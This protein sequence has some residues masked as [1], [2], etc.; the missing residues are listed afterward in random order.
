MNF[1]NM[2][3]NAGKMNEMNQQ[4]FTSMIKVGEI[5]TESHSKLVGKQTA[6]MEA[7]MAAFTKIVRSK[8]WRT[9]SCTNSRMPSTSN[10]GGASKFAEC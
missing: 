6:A 2:L 7:N 5:V 1:E 9:S 3:P 10:I 8:R 4:M